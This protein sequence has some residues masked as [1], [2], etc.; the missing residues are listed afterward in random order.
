MDLPALYALAFAVVTTVA[1]LVLFR[2]GQRVF[3]PGKTVAK[4][5]GEANPARH[6]LQVGQ[7]L[8][9]F[10]V[11]A[12]VV[13]NCVEGESLRE[14]VFSAATFG[15]LGIVLVALTGELGT[16]LLLRS[17]LPAEI[18]R[19]NV[20]AGVAGGSHY[21]ATG[22]VAAHAIA[23]T[24]LRDVGLS[25]LFF[26][27]AIATLWLFVSLFRALTTYDD[28]EQIQGENL[29]A[30]LSY[31]GLSIAV[32]IIVGCALDGDFVTWDVSLKGYA[33]ILALSLAL[34]PVR[35]LFVQSLLLGAPLTFRGG[36][37]DTG[38]GTDRN[39]GLGA[40]EAATY[41]ATALSVARLV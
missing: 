6:L 32:A 26:F 15:V 20:A 8:G 28:A 41:I 22:I 5:F 7:V 2:L 25:L 14:D 33:S 34:Y 17:R 16:R 10:F 29:A 27:I 11:A 19:G 9:V 36:R 31:A 3:S 21:V 24:K 13:K 39:E 38:I 35:Q 1:L 30:A 37:L 23:G 40:L 18:A 4:D 12:S